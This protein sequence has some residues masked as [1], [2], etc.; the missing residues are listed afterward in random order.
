MAWSLE[1]S[2]NWVVTPRTA[3]ETRRE[4]R[5]RESKHTVMLF[6]KKYQ[7]IDTGKYCSDKLETL[8]SQSWYDLIERDYYH[9]EGTSYHYWTNPKAKKRVESDLKWF[10]PKDNDFEI[11][12]K[13]ER[14]RKIA[15]DKAI[16]KA[17]REHREQ[18]EQAGS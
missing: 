13:I 8:N 4:L 17:Q 2:H 16:W 1:N 6:D 14:E 7:D 10:E 11:E 9:A 15:A 18:R 5:V 3:Y 12:D